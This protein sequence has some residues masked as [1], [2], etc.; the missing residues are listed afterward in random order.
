MLARPSTRSPNERRDSDKVVSVTAAGSPERE[1]LD[2][3]DALLAAPR[4]HRVGFGVTR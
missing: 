1:W 3:L 4:G 2:A